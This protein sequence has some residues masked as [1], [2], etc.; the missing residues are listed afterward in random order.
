MIGLLLKNWKF[1]IDVLLVLA[2]VI[3][4]FWW[5]PM[6]IF[7]GGLK[8]EDTGNLV[9]EVNEIGE[10][11]TAEYYGEVITSIDE[12]RINPLQNEEISE[13]VAA[14]Y[15][16]LLVALENLKA[17][18]A[19]DV[20]ERVEEYRQGEK[21][22]NWRR[23]IKHGVDSRNIMEKLDYHGFLIELQAEPLFDDLLE[24]L[25]REKTGSEQ[26]ESPKEKEINGLLFQI[27]RDLGRDEMLTDAQRVRFIQT[28][29]A[30]INEG[31]SR[32]TARKKL[33]MIG[34]GWVKAGFDFS[35]LGE[36]S[37]IYYKDLA[38]VHLIGITPKI[39]NADINP[40]FIP[41]KGIPGFQILDEK[42]PVN[43]YDAK[44]VKQYCIDKLTVYAHQ[45][46]ILENAKRQGA[47]TL[48][49]LFSLLT[50]N[51]IKK[52]IFH[53]NPFLDFI[54]EAEEDEMV[55]YAEAYILD[56]LVRLEAN[57]IKVLRSSLRNR[58]IN[59]AYAD[60]RSRILRQVLTRFQQYPYQPSGKPFNYF[61]KM[62][63]DI[64]LDS[65][66][67]DREDSL[68]NTF[69]GAIEPSRVLESDSM[70]KE[71][72]VWYWMDKP[73]QYIND[74]NDLINSLKKKGAL[75]SIPDS[76]LIGQQAVE[77]RTAFTD[78]K[79]VDYRLI[80]EKDS[81]MLYYLSDSNTRQ[82]LINMLYPMSIEAENLDIFMKRKDIYLAHQALL[83]QKLDADS[84]GYVWL[85]DSQTD[86]L[87]VNKLAINLEDWLP[88]IL[89]QEFSKADY[90]KLNNNMIFIQQ[91]DSLGNLLSTKTQLLNRSQSKE[92]EAFWRALLH[93]HKE[94]QNK[95]FLE[96][97]EDWINSRTKN[98]EG[99]TIYLNSNG[100]S[101]K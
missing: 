34:R 29:H 79:V 67:D 76:T 22:W 62:G 81:V 6:G 55:T 25:W 31:I 19:M 44:R 49:N 20:K 27:Y 53:E 9:T 37:I 94:E 88:E 100:L 52:V 86:S 41:E 95:S 98:R 75:R 73:Y 11:V 21:I 3:L 84:T 77:E 101:I 40:W 83:I 65:L 35:D 23:I 42:G 45:A 50:G 8:L 10:L 90:L 59:Q 18:Q 46:Q 28:Y 68:L 24:F 72:L 57:E 38:E 47:E 33:T 5:N 85:Y 66:I 4:L 97:T 64:A 48:Q 69:R 54:Q 71:L 36:E 43:F 15:L 93:L 13:Q 32:R 60:Q 70:D 74:Y 30:N 63:T 91:S 51:E 39:L 7:G 26:G 58:S 17:Y 96:K 92:F 99:A 12:A 80:P 61:S 14:L 2:V 89:V 78:Y 82:Y 56:S 1:I 87:R 16:D